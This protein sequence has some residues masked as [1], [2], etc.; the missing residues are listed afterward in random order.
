MKRI[1]SSMGNTLLQG[2]WAPTLRYPFKLNLCYPCIKT[3]LSSMYLDY[4][5]IACNIWVNQMGKNSAFIVKVC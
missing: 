2:I 5:R 4:T 3:I 1:F